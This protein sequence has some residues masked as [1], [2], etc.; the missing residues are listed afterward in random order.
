MRH[1]DNH[2]FSYM[3]F[4]D[5]VCSFT[6]SLPASDFD[7]SIYPIPTYPQALSPEKPTAVCPTPEPAATAAGDKDSVT[8]SDTR[9]AATVSTDSELS[10]SEPTT[11]DKDFF[12]AL[13]CLAA[14]RS[15][16]P[17]R[18]VTAYHHNC[19]YI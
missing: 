1:Y 9:A 16:D 12:M 7:P 11:D 17:S 18:Q 4:S 8:E 19:I 10:E 6:F 13:A 3:F 15:K 2:K 14:R 5:D